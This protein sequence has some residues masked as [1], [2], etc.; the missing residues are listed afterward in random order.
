MAGV[1]ELPCSV[2]VED[3]PEGIRVP[4]KEVLLAF[5]IIKEVFLRAAEQGVR[6]A[7]QSGSPGLKTT[8][9]DI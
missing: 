5:L 7:V 1:V 4:V 8:A 3:A 9:A 2:E 6:V